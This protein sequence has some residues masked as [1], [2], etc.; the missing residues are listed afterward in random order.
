VGAVSSSG[1]E[2][3]STVSGASEETEYSDL[4]K[5]SSEVGLKGRDSGRKT[6]GR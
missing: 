1:S 5:T 2:L 6:A 4:K 3:R